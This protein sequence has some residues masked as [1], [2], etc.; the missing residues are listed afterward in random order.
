[1][2]RPAAV[3][4]V[5]L[6][7]VGGVACSDSGDGA[8][9]GP[10]T[11]SSTLSF[12]ERDVAFQL[13]AAATGMNLVASDVGLRSVRGQG[14]AYCRDTA[15]GELQPHRAA[16]EAASDTEVRQA[17]QRALAELDRAIELCGGDAGP[18]AIQEAIGTYTTSFERLLERIEAAT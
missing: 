2:V 6:A 12:D 8:G 4:A 15:P 3:L 11:T 5:V 9:A 14:G 13:N 7:V 17:A 16:L 18:A 1:M 10:S